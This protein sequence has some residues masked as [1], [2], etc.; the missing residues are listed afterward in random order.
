MNFSFSAYW[1]A[2]A[3]GKTSGLSERLLLGLLIPLSLPYALIQRLRVGLYR[4]GILKSRHLPRPVISIGNITVGGTG[5]T[6]VTAW[7]ARFLL[8]NGLKVAVLSRGYGG[9]LEGRTAIV[10]DG[11]E[12]LLTA[13]QC[14]DEPYLL[15]SS[16][17]GLIVV[18]GSDRHSAGSLALEQLSPDIFLLDDGFQHLALQRDLNILLL[19]SVRPFGNGNILPAGMLREPQSAALRADLIIH[20]RCTQSIENIPA[21]TYIPQICERHTLVDLVP[22][23]GGSPFTFAELAGLPLFAFA[24]IAEPDSFFNDLK[25]A[26]LNLVRALAL[27]DHARYDALEAARLLDVMVSSGAAYAV[28][29]EKDGVKLAPLAAEIGSLILLA[30]MEPVFDGCDILEHELLIFLQK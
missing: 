30:R 14:G 12:I 13:E 23:T 10:S 26:G 27:T 9:A 20:T 21:L 11:R 16:I 15:A 19:D 6:P 7:I 24:G 3:N 25:A 5:K 18:I 28:T 22:L 4:C 17:P 2:L 8:S 29:T 1:R